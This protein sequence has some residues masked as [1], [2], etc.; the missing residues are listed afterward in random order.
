MALSTVVLMAN[1]A[2]IINGSEVS[3]S[4]TRYKAMIGLLLND[5]FICGGTAIAPTWV[6]TAAHCVYDE[7]QN[8][9]DPTVIKVLTDT[10]NN[11]DG[12]GKK[13]QAKRI[14]PHSGYAGDN[15]DIALIELS[16]PV[17]SYAPI[18]RSDNLKEGEMVTITGWG[19]TAIDDYIYPAKLMEV[20]VPV[21]DLSTCNGPNSYNNTLFDTQICAGYMSGANIK[22][23]CQGDSGGP[24]WSKGSDGSLMLSG[25]VSYGGSETQSCAAPNFPGIYTKVSSFVS[26]IEGYTGTLSGG[27]STTS[28]GDTTTTTTTTALTKSDID[29]LSSGEWHM[30]GTT[31]AISDMSIFSGVKAVLVYT[32]GA[33]KAYSP[34]S[35][36]ASKLSSSGYGTLSSIA[37]NSGMWIKK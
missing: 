26:W 17:S 25:V 28:G 35:E 12:S 2:R 14:I 22:D 24:L 9:Q 16:A 33:Y 21:I 15:N 30:V 37:A 3:S 1:D 20:D 31:G 7:Y 36:I 29:A 6:V 18:N 13:I 27:S 34:D 10:Y 8:V 19:N 23:S 4:D 5:Q 11:A 32:N